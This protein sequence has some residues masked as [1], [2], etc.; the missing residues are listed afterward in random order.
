MNPRQR[1]FLFLA[2]GLALGWVGPVRAT[3]FPATGLGDV[4]AEGGGSG[5]W[6]LSA[7]R[8]TSALPWFRGSEVLKSRSS[9]L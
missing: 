4:N 8:A 6:H 3:G 1:L 2:A 7:G 5:A 9:L